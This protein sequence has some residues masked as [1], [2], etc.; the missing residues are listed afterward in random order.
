MKNTHFDGDTISHKKWKRFA[1]VVKSDKKRN[2][3]IAN[4]EDDRDNYEYQNKKESR[5]V[6]L[7]SPKVRHFWKAENES[8]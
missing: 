2:R 7:S 1:S 4:V 5:W 6:N 3:Y 8:K